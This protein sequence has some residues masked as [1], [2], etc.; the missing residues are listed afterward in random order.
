MRTTINLPHELLRALEKQAAEQ[1]TTVTAL[2]ED[3]LR[4]SVAG[5]YEAHHGRC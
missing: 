1:S 5:K 4:A 2:I 3:S